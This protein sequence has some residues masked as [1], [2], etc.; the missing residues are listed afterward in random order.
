[1]TPAARVIRPLR[2]FLATESAGGVVLLLAA[3]AA[4]IWANSP[5]Q[6]SYV[7]FWS[8]DLG[9]GRDGLSMDL[10]HWVNDGL[11]TLFFFV[12]GLE[13][14][15]ELVTGELRDRRVAALPALAALGGMIVPALLYLAFNHSGAAAEGWGIPMATDI[16]IAVGVLS[17][18]SRRVPASLK[19]FLLAL[20]IVDDIGAIIVIAFFYSSGIEPVWL[21]VAALVFVAMG[22][23]RVAGITH[24]APLVVLGVALWFAML[25]SGVHATIAG[26]VLALVIPARETAVVEHSLHPWTSLVIVPLFVLANAGVTITGGALSDALDSSITQG[27]IVGLVVGKLIGITGFAWLA[28]RL[29]LAVMPKGADWN[30]MV[31]VAAI[32]GIGFTVSIF[33]ASLAYGGERLDEAKIGILVGSLLAAGLGTL[34]VLRLPRQESMDEGAS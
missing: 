5:W 9:F 7:E 14:K 21:L 18:F 13:I 23:L 17:M 30:G 24:I 34:L 4:L 28:Q 31:A 26:V 16:A 20:A 33:I 25:E 11:M 6:D 19:L 15:R 1:M 32:G 12:V 3:L 22:L 8:T 2:D 10:Q 27:V 29:R